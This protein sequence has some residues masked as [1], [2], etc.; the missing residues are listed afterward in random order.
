[1]TGP[2]W[3]RCLKWAPFMD[4]RVT[5]VVTVCAGGTEC[6]LCDSAGRG[7]WDACAWPPPSFIS[8]ARGWFCF[9]TFC[10]SGYYCL[11][12]SLSHWTRR[13]SRGSP[14]Q[15]SQFLNRWW[16]I[17]TVEKQ[18]KKENSDPRLLAFLPLNSPLLLS[19]GWAWWFASNVWNS[20]NVMDVTSEIRLPKTA[21]SKC[22]LTL[23]G[24]PLWL[25]MT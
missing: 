9:E 12:N 5:R 23:S 3:K 1:M 24:S 14:S 11:M 10:C 2:P 22:P 16:S 7:C 6:I 18:R 21:T 13:W 20:A 17:T 25:C 4:R 8:F 15:I 19:V